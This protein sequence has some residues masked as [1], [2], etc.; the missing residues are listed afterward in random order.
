MSYNRENQFQSPQS[1]LH[2]FVRFFNTLHDY[3]P[4]A[5]ITYLGTPQFH[6]LYFPSAWRAMKYF[7]RVTQKFLRKHAPNWLQSY[8]LFE[9]YQ[10]RYQFDQYGHITEECIEIVAHRLQNILKSFSANRS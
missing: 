2:T 7:K 6:K 1:R 4:T 3:F 5:T 10:D 9:N 8:P